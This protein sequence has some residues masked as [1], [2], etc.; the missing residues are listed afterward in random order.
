MRAELEILEKID[1]YLSGKMSAADKLLFENQ[2]ASDPVLQGMVN[3]Q[4]LMIRTVSRQAMLSEIN[5]VAGVGTSA[6]YSA[7]GTWIAS[8]LII[9]GII[10]GLVIYNME[11]E[12]IVEEQIAEVIES[13]E[14]DNSSLFVMDDDTTSEEVLPEIVPAPIPIAP[15][16]ITSNVNNIAN[17]VNIVPIDEFESIELI[18]T[19]PVDVNQGDDSYE[20]N[21]NKNKVA[22]YPGGAI[23]MKK[24]F[25]KN[26]RFPGTAKK[27]K[28]EGN[29]R[30]NFWVYTTGII[31]VVSSEC[32]ALKGANQKPFSGFKMMMN[33]KIQ[34]LFEDEARRLI[35]IM[36]TWEPATDKTGN[37]MATMMEIY[38]DFDIDGHS[39]AYDL[40]EDKGEQ[41][42]DDREYEGQ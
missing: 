23:P 16:V 21:M 12:T 2:I 14:S 19:L 40:D 32:V 31:E 17:N 28:I 38:I 22:S 37:P 13:P 24:Y 11:P 9:I 33:L 29:V 39:S 42:I 5:A 25:K 35:R 27:K 41:S 1:I 6:W 15:Y 34:K 7:S 30:V 18:D 20:T 10:T 26:L 36:P 8:G 3:D 4:Q